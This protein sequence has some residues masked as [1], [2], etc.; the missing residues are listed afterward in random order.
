MKTKEVVGRFETNKI[1]S[2]N[3]LKD[4]KYCLTVTGLLIKEKFTYIGT[5]KY[6]FYTNNDLLA[7]AAL[8]SYHSG[9][10]LVFSLT[11]NGQYKD[12]IIG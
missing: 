11:Q 1:F 8:I 7:D 4:G 10:K 2:L 12:V 6:V 3:S 5:P 9:N